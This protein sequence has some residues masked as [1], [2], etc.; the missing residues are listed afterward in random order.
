M[1]Q[2]LLVRHGQASWGADDY[3]V[4]SPTGWEQGRRLG[5]ALAAR[6]VAPD[7]VVRGTMRRHRETLE[8]LS[9]GAEGLAL[10]TGEVDERWDE[11]DSADVLRGEAPVPEEAPEDFRAWFEAAIGRWTGGEHAGDYVEPYDVFT[12]RIE[13][14]LAAAAARRGTVLVV[15]SGGPISWCLAMLLGV[16]LDRRGQVDLAQRLN[17]LCVNSGVSKV[18]SG[19]RGL[20]AVQF[21]EHTHLE[22]EPGLITY[23]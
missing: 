8:A 5:R 3:D 18:V 14:A 13:Q 21:N 4:L 22:P 19:R 1:G 10:P 7:A 9:E 11:F 23:R 6:G 15:S 16:D 12:A 17:P 2:V 20:S